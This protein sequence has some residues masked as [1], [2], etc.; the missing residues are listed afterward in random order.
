MPTRVA[1]TSSI[2]A[3]PIA[4]AVIRACLQGAVEA[5]EAFVTLANKLVASTVAGA[6]VGA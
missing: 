2:V 3:I 6:I 4:R 5:S 1:E